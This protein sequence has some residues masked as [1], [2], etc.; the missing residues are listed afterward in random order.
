MGGRGQYPDADGKFVNAPIF[1]FND[2]KLKFNT[3]WVNKPNDNYGSVSA[4]FPKSL[5][6]RDNCHPA[7]R[8]RAV[9]YLSF[10]ERIHPPSI[11]P[12]SSTISWMA[13]Y[14][15]LSSAFTSFMS[16]RNTH[17]RF[18][19]ALVFSSRGSLS[20]FAAWLARRIYLMM[21]SVRL[22]ARCQIV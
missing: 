18:S 7:L 22:S 14:F 8:R 6:N 15:L 17:R 2:G 13:V 10:V 19:F 1:N 12:I 3:N 21:S 5:L 9:S 20:A 11:L 4:F 16:R